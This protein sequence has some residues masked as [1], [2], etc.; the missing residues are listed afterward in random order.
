MGAR[1]TR[2]SSRRTIAQPACSASRGR[3]RADGAD[4]ARTGDRGEAD[5]LWPEFLPG[6]QRCLFTMTPSPGGL[7]RRPD[8]RRSICDTGAQRS[9]CAAAATPTMCRPAILSTLPAAPCVPSPS[10]SPR[11]EIRGTPVPV[12]PRR[13]DD[14]VRGASTMPCAGDGTLVYVGAPVRRAAA[15]PR[16]DARVGGPGRARKSRSRR[17]RARTYT[18]AVARRHT[19]RGRVQ[20]QE[21]TSGFGTWAGRRSPASRST[22][23]S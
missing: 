13:G 17:R 6:G 22:P 2:S 12:H 20:D 14:D 21:P 18:A 5:H 16:A 7:R 1:W 15:A 9:S 3:W 4:S 19:H 8:G 23:G 10:I 11:L